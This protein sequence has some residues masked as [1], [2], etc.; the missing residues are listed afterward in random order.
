MGRIKDRNKEGAIRLH[1]FCLSSFHSCYQEP[2]P[3]PYNHSRLGPSDESFNRLAPSLT[4]VPFNDEVTIF[5]TILNSL[6]WSETPS[7]T[8]VPLTRPR[9]RK[10]NPNSKGYDDR[11]GT[12]GNRRS[13]VPQKDRKTRRKRGRCSSNRNYNVHEFIVFELKSILRMFIQ[14]GAAQAD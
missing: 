2:D 6:G 1:H 4:E 9:G 10:P 5:P 7:T 13:F 14:M 8:P 11:A 3:N 12:G